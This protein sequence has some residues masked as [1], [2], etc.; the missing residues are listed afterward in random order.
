MIAAQ[1]VV[2]IVA[3]AVTD[4]PIAPTEATAKQT[5]V[6]IALTVRLGAATAVKHARR[7]A[8]LVE[9]FAETG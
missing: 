2:P 5:V 1:N 7:I 4:R 3:I 6:P 8:T 9:M